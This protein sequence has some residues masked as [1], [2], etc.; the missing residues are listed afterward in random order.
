MSHVIKSIMIQAQ[1][2]LI[3]SVFKMNINNV[4]ASIPTSVN[5]L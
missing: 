1:L 2:S 5:T 4:L 3:S